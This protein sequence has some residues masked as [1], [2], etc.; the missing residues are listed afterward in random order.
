MSKQ[1]EALKGKLARLQSQ[2]SVEREARLAD[3][4]KIEG[5]IVRLRQEQER[6]QRQYDQTRDG[7]ERAVADLQKQIAALVVEEAIEKGRTIADEL[8]KN[9]SD[10]RLAELDHICR[11]LYS[12]VPRRLAAGHEQRSL[13][14]R[15]MRGDADVKYVKRP[16]PDYGAMFRSW[17]RPTKLPE[18]VV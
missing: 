5:D 1:L 15:R 6:L 7:G 10:E 9:Y 4:L 18:G 17:L 16:F 2:L 8:G 13:V 11:V 12:A 14:F 3:A